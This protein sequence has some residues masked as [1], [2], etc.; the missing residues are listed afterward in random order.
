MNKTLSSTLKTA[1]SVAA[2]LIVI[3]VAAIALLPSLINTST[4]KESLIQ[5]VKARTGQA[6]T[7]EG[8]LSLS[9]FPWLGIKTGKVTLSQSPDISDQD[10]LQ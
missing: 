10:L 6:L 1:G 4:F 9:V 2:A 7:I 3:I 5:Q 8:D